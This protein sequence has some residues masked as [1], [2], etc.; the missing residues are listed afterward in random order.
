MLPGFYY[1]R[2][3]KKKQKIALAMGIILF[4]LIGVL[5][6][7]FFFRSPE[8]ANA[9]KTANKTILNQQ[10]TVEL[11][12][13]YSCGHTKTTL[14]NLPAELKGKNQEETALLHP[15]WTIL[16]FNENFIVAEQK[17]TSECDDHFL[18]FL[19]ENEIIVTNSKDKNKILSKQKINPAILTEEDIEILSK[20]IFISSEYELLEILESFQ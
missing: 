20:G 8:P 3:R 15:E 18:L 1:E 12:M 17:E 5:I 19:T 16:N 11:T 13:L 9:V 2:Q 10:A 14:I 4:L 7:V 6:A